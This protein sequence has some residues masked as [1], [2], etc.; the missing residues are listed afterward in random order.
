MVTKQIV[1]III[2]LLFK[3][4]FLTPFV[5]AQ[6]N[7]T[8]LDS[9]VA[10]GDSLFTVKEFDKARE[11][12]KAA[13]NIDKNLIQAYAGLGKIAIAEK[14][15]GD[16][17]DKFQHI[18][19]RDPKN[20]DAHYYRGIC[21]RET[22]KFKVL[23]LRKLDW[24][25][26]EKMFQWVIARDSLYRDVIYQFARLQRFREKYTEAI[27]LV[28]VQIR[29]RPELVEPQVKLFRFYR[30]F[31][32]HT[33]KD[34]AIGWLNQRPWDQAK[35]AIGEKLRREG[36]LAK[37]DSVF[38]AL[39]RRPLTMPRQP[40]FLSL[41]KIYYEQDQPQQAEK[42]YWYAT[43]EIKNNVAADLVFEDVKYISTDQE[44][45]EYYSLKSIPEK[46]YFF[47]KLWISRDPTPASSVN[48]RL[49]EHYRRL[50][51][52]EKNYEYDG[53]RTWFNN[54][55]KTGYL[56]F[57]RTYDL[58]HEFND[59]G[60]IY[61]RHGQYDDWAITGG[62]DVPSNESWMYYKTTGTPEMIFH[63]VL[64]NTASYW[65]FTPII[66]DPRLLQD[67]VQFGNI[68]H[69]LLSANQLERLAYTEEMARESRKYVSTGL[70]TDRHTWEKKI[71]PLETPFSMTTFRGER[72]KTILE[73]YNAFSLSELTDNSNNKDQNIELEQGL[74]IHNLTWQEIEKY[75]E[76]VS[77]PVKKSESFIDLYRFEVPPDSYHVAFYL[78]PLETDFLG[79][80]KY[81][82]RIPAY[83]MAELSISD[84]ELATKI[85][86]ATKAGKFEK[87]GLLVIPNPTRL[88]S[89]KTPVYIY[90]EIYQLSKD[91]SG[92][93]SFTI[94]YTLARLEA[95]RTGLSRLFGGGGKSSITTR[96]D[97]EGKDE[98][99]VEYLAIDV[100]K[101]KA[102][103]YELTV[104]VTDQHN[105]N[106]AIQTRKI[107][108]Q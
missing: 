4:L 20:I 34:N 107:A 18:L 46:I 44:L 23:L 36:D 67:R 59:K 91:P 16:A 78:R 93:T 94:E 56:N 63:F 92:N 11:A 76:K 80:W 70:S 84:I 95:K 88:F 89:R 38:L 40:I 102:G 100:S 29:L 22:G 71:K 47:K 98:F 5:T 64:E 12:Y 31:I 9:L 81:E 24:D 7:F 21:K 97:R 14:K 83:S 52:A 65:R 45:D 27:Q 2:L 72:G 1:N 86:P 48:Y 99:S 42:Y 66:T 32:T 61:I 101:V 15:W 28:H 73:I 106:T 68:Y 104:K 53:F 6:Q 51:H 19:D 85:E 55:D 75:Q 74:T 37:A 25:K 82:K 35:Y 43:N 105:G 8:S 79:G 41:A 26:S 58:N 103:E 54:P 10:R 108:L 96:I 57:T 87:N 13:L 49:A 62:Q 90:F 3:C 30:Y 69:R 33:K 77:V 50:I 17:D 60:L 39:L